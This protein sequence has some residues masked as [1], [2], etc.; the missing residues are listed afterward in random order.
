M[1]LLQRAAGE[2]EKPPSPAMQPIKAFINTHTQ[3]FFPGSQP[4]KYYKNYCV[5]VQGSYS[6][7]VGLLFL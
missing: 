1:V 5:L 2:T 3:C 6:G 7:G 4:L